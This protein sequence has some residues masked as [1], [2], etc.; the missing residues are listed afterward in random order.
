MESQDIRLRAGGF[1][2]EKV[3]KNLFRKRFLIHASN[4]P[5]RVNYTKPFSEVSN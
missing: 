5:D 1:D 4:S 3:Q 2:C